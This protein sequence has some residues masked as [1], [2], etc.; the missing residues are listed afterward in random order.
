PR[1]WRERVFEVFQRG[2][3]ALAV[4]TERGGAGVGL[5]VCRAIAR[6]HGGELR[7]RARAHGGSSFELWLPLDDAAPPPLP[8]PPAGAPE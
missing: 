7:L 5:A 2:P 1:P 6:A 8:D 4:P 3:Q